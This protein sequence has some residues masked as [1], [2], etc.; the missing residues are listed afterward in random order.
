MQQQTAAPRVQPE[1]LRTQ[2]ASKF[3]GISG[4]HLHALLRNNQGPPSIRLGRARL[5]S[6]ASLR[7]FMRQR[8][9]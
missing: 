5:F 1:Y 8:E 6:V 4:P 7:E 2:N 9:Q 3:L